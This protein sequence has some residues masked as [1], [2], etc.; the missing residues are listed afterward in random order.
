MAATFT[1]YEE[2]GVPAGGTAVDTAVAVHL[3]LDG[4][5][6]SWVSTVG[7]RSELQTLSVLEGPGQ[8]QGKTG[9]TLQLDCENADSQGRTAM[10]MFWHVDLV[11]DPTYVIVRHGCSRVIAANPD[12]YS[13]FDVAGEHLAQLAYFD[14]R[15]RTSWRL[16]VAASDEPGAEWFT[17]VIA[18]SNTTTR[19][20]SLLIFR[21]QTAG[22]WVLIPSGVN[23]PASFAQ[24]PVAPYDFLTMAVIVDRQNN[25][26]MRVPADLRLLPLSTPS[27]PEL[28]PILPAPADV[29]S[30]TFLTNM[31]WTLL[32]LDGSQWLTTAKNFAV[33]VEGPA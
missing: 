8:E 13:T 1:H 6:R 9:W 4:L 5:L 22:L 25:S 31:G 10:W 21:E 14:L 12:A 27:A 29:A 11:G 7:E 30:L 33:R 15:Y 18:Q 28:M 2:F 32:F 17:A 20:A 19:S 24:R 3:A 23:G 26:S 16:T